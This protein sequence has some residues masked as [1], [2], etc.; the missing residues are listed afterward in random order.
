MY[1]NNAF[2]NRHL[3]LSFRG[4]IVVAAI[5]RE[6]IMLTRVQKP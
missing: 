2:Q 4:Y 5:G 6:N 1:V 3:L